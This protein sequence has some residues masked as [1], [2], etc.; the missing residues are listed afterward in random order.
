M[1]DYTQY[2]SCMFKFKAEHA[3]SL[4]LSRQKS[5]NNLERD[6]T[7]IP[8]TRKDFKL[9][10]G[11]I[12]VKMDYTEVLEETPAFTLFKIFFRQFL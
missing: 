5:T 6:E 10:D 4:Q 7:Y 9:P 1:A 8:P 11:K 3:T 2:T 12:A